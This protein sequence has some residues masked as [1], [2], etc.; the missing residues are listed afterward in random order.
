MST[1]NT[2]PPS[3][4]QGLSDDLDQWLKEQLQRIKALEAEGRSLKLNF[5]QNARE[6]G[7]LL[8]AV[9][10]RLQGS[11]LN[12]RQWIVR[13]TDIGYSTALL[14]M[15]VALN[16]DVVKDRFAD[17]NPLELTVRGIR[18]AIR[19]QRQTQG[20]GKPGSGRRAASDGTEPATAEAS[21]PAAGDPADP[22]GEGEASDPGDGAVSNTIRREPEASLGATQAAEPDRVGT[23]ASAPSLGRVTVV[24]TVFSDGDQ[25]V[26][27]KALAEWS[28]VTKSL[29]GSKHLGTLSATAPSR[30]IGTVMAKLAGA[31][32]QI[33]PRKATVKIDQ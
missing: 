33:L 17:S 9:E 27:Q 20:G 16:Y 3:A 11:P 1:H 14:W 28:P 24:V 21:V 15:D 23:T 12:F 19:D 4:T 31:L 8:I 30:D 10:Q 25:A 18:D 32:T 5:V 7:D 26:V 2:S 13:D 22:S 29:G 6:K